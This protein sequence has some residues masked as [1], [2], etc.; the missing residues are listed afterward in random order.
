M[1]AVIQKLNT[2]PDVNGTRLVQERVQLAQLDALEHRPT[3]LVKPV[4]QLVTI[5]R[6]HD[7]DVRLAT[8]SGHPNAR[9]VRVFANALPDRGV[10]SRRRADREGTHRLAELRDLILILDRDRVDEA[11]GGVLMVSPTDH[12]HVRRG[13]RAR[14]LGERDGSGADHREK[15]QPT[16]NRYPHGTTLGPIAEQPTV[17]TV[18]RSTEKFKVARPSPY[19]PLAR[20]QP[21][22]SVA[23]YDKV[24]AARKSQVKAD[25]VGHA[26]IRLEEMRMPGQDM[27]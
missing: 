25:I 10:V 11:V 15:R 13:L 14:R 18:R 19:S 21:P 17:E 3:V 22:A 7:D 23:V 6:D 2:L 20:L 12:D 1:T 9:R 4:E 5:V 26:R 27:R 16:C 8:I 24:R